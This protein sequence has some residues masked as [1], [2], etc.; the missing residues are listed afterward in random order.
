MRRDI[1]VDLVDPWL[2]NK[3]ARL[4]CSKR[5]KSMSLGLNNTQT[6]PDEHDIIAIIG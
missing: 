2:E 3:Q 6:R 4:M 5:T 1:A